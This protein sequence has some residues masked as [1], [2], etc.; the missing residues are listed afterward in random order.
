MLDQKDYVQGDP[1]PSQLI[2]EQQEDEE[3]SDPIEASQQ[4]T[5]NRNISKDEALN[6][7]YNT[8]LTSD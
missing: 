6:M 1:L 4:I 3:Y 8:D 2:Q 7:F 5:L